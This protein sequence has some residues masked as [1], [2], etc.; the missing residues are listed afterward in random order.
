MRSPIR[1]ITLL[2]SLL[3]ACAATPVLAQT[4]DQAHV[5]AQLADADSV[6]RYLKLRGTPGYAKRAFARLALA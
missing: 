2:V 4:K 5:A 3:G 6:G 1:T